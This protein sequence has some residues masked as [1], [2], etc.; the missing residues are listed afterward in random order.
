MEVPEFGVRLAGVTYRPRVGAYAIIIDPQHRVVTIET[1][2]ALFLPGGGCHPGE[3][4]EVTLR[5]E[6]REECGY[7]LRTYRRIGEAVDYFYA[8]SEGI[9]YRLHSV[10]FA[11]AFGA[12]LDVGVEADQR[13]L[14][15]DLRTVLERLQRPSQVW[16]VRQVLRGNG[17]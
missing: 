16:A 13:L 12:R 8:S 3:A 2:Q 11:A 14:W 1:Q 10:F 17:P 6:V 4:P 7:E 9:H 15:L 5:R